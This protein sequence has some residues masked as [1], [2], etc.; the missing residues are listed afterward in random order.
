MR[1]LLM[2]S[3]RNMAVRA[4]YTAVLSSRHPGWGL[5]HM[6]GP[7]I[8]P[9]T[10]AKGYDVLVYEL[11]APGDPKRYRDLLAL[12]EQINELGIR[13]ITHIEGPYREGVTAELAERGIIV[14]EEPFTL[15][16][17]AAALERAAPPPRKRRKEQADGEPE[18]RGLLRGLFRR[19]P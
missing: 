1:V 7:P 11:D 6:S 13:V 2:I 16:H 3:N 4:L 19:K 10:I 15:E 18:R 12:W 17:V 8:S 14:V 9:A 5:S